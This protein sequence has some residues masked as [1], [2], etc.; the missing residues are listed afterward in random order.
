MPGNKCQYFN[1]F[2]TTTKFPNLSMF[3]IPKDER[4]QTWII[5]SGNV[6]LLSLDKTQLYNR[7][8][9]QE[10]FS[11]DSFMNTSNKNLKPTAIPYKHNSEQAGPSTSSGKRCLLL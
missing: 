6:N 4:H 3:R 11:P 7:Y 1:C 2:K 8:I 9:C 10:H 5:N